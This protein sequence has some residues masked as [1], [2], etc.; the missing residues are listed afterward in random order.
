MAALKSLLAIQ[1]RCSSRTVSTGT[2]AAARHRLG[3]VA[4]RLRRSSAPKSSAI[5][6]A[7]TGPIPFMSGWLARKLRQPSP[8][9][10]PPSCPMNSAANCRPYFG[11]SSHWPSSVTRLVLP[12]EHLAGERDEVSVRGAKAPAEEC[13]PRVERP[14]PRRRGDTAVLG[15][16]PAFAMNSPPRV[17]AEQISLHELAGGLT[18]GAEEDRD[19]DSRG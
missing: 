16:T 19:A 2:F 18:A 9:P 6:R 17:R 12:D 1:I 11:C 10:V 15:A 8:G 5:S 13:R 4:D 7:F 14:S 3:S